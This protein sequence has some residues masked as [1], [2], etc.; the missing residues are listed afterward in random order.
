MYRWGLRL[1]LA[2]MDF[3]VLFALGRVEVLVLQI[4]NSAFVEMLLLM[5]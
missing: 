3:P 5:L 2:A 4:R 1:L